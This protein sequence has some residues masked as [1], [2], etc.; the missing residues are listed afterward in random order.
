MMNTR[1]FCNNLNLELNSWRSRLAEVSRHFDE[2][3]SIDKYRLTTQIEG[4]HIL[5]TELDDR[6][7]E[8]LESCPT[9]EWRVGED[10]VGTPGVSIKEDAGTSAKHDYDF[11]G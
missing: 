8:L 6:M 2:V 7:N 10:V 1:E 4:L 5:L 3:P 11:G 9:G